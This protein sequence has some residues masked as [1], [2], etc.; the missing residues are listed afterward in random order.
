[1]VQTRID[2]MCLLMAQACSYAAD[3]SEAK[4]VRW[5]RQIVWRMLEIGA[6]CVTRVMCN[7]GTILA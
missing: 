2:C 7:A 6:C 5:L 4:H 3:V 1:M